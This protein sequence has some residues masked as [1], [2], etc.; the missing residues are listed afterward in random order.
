MDARLL[1]A[2]YRQSLTFVIF[3]V[4]F[5]FLFCY[6]FF[7]VNMTDVLALEQEPSLQQWNE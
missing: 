6:D 4:A 1:N 2:S 5:G 3:H 7:F